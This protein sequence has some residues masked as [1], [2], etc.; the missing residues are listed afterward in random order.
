MI[1]FVPSIADRWQRTLVVLFVLSATA[2]F[3]AAGCGGSRVSVPRSSDRYEY[4]SGRVAYESKHWMDAQTHLKR[5]LDV[6][7]GHAVADS[8]QFLLGMAHFWVGRPELAAPRSWTAP[9][10]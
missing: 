7:P 10:G 6:H 4:E 2:V 8:A 5:F 3:W 1:P 9:F